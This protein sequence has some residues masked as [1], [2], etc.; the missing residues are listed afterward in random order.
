MGTK[1]EHIVDGRY[2]FSEIVD[3]NRLRNMLGSFSRAT[4][5]GCELVTHPGWEELI[6]TGQPEI[7]GEFCRRYPATKEIC[8]QSKRE[9]NKLISKKEKL[10]IRECD[11]G[12]TRG[13]APVVIQG[14]HAVDLLIGPVLLN[15]PGPKL[16]RKRSENYG[17]DWGSYLNALRQLPVAREQPLREA[18]SFLRDMVVILAERGLEEVKS[19]EAARE[20]MES[21]DNLHTTLSSIGDAV[22]ATDID[23]RIEH[24]NPIAQNLTGWAM[25]EA[26][27][28]KLEKV[29][30]IVNSATGEKAPNPVSKVLEEGKIVG[31]ANHTR[32]ISRDGNQYQIADSGS[33]IKDSGGK[34]TGVVLVF[35]DVSEEYRMREE[36]RKS[37]E[38]LDLAMSI[39][40][41]GVWDW[42]LITDDV[43]FDKRYYE[44][45]G[46]R[47]GEFP[48]RLEEFQ[49]RTHPKDID[50]VMEN[51]RKY[52]EGEIPRFSVEFRFRKKR[53][54]WMW[55]LG[56]GRIVER[57]EDSR[58]TRFVGTHTDITDRKMAEE[59]LLRS[60][61]RMEL[62]L[63]GGDLGAWDWNVASGELTFDERWAEMLGYLKDEIEPDRTNWDKLVHPDD[64]PAV[65]KALQDHLKGRTE[66]FES[67][68]RLLH[69]SGEWVWILAKGMVIERDSEGNPL[70]ACGTHLDITDR[71]K[72]Q[73]ELVQSAELLRATLE[74]T[75]NGILVVNSEGQILA[76]NEKFGEMW[77]IPSDLLIAGRDNSLLKYVKNQLV[78]PE[79]FFG[80]V[81]KLYQNPE[82]ISLDI[83]YFQDGRI[84]ER[85]S[86]PLY[87][88]GEAEGRVWSFRD[89][90]ERKRAEEAL[91]TSEEKYRTLVSSMSD[92]IFLLSGEDRFVDVHCKPGGALYACPED[93]LGKKIDEVLPP[94]VINSYRETAR[95]VRRTGE[96]QRYEYPLKIGERDM[97]FTATLD[98]HEDGERVIADIRDVTERKKAQD[99]L[100]R[101]QKLESVGTLAG[102]IAHDFNNILT[103]LYGN[104]ELAGKEL[105]EDHPAYSHIQTANQSLERA[106]HLTKQLLT[107]AKGGEPLLESVDIRKVVRDSVQFDL[108]GSNVKAQLDLDDNLWMVK[109]DRG[110]LSHVFANL[111]INA[112]EAMPVGGFIHIS[113]ENVIEPEEGTASHLAGDYVKI[114]IR[115]EGV[116]IP[117][118]LIERIFDPYF[119]TKQAGSGLGL[120]IVHSIVSKHYGHITA[121]SKEGEGTVFT[122]YL[123]ADKSYQEVPGG[124]QEDS[125][126]E[127][128]I[129]RGRILVMD[130]EEMVRNVSARMLK[131]CG[132]APELAVNGKD[133][134]NKYLS[135]MESGEP[136]EAV[137]VDLTVPGGMGGKKLTEELLKTDPDARIIVTSGYSTDPVLANYSQYGFSGRIAKPFQVKELRKELSRVL[138]D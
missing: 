45:A 21:E 52:L 65:Q 134:L 89:I 54:G 91:K 41:E 76:T 4:R 38:R 116:G 81:E 127:T 16:F 43:F 80:R 117:D 25:E 133:A 110:Q 12:L 28:K 39:K 60:E 124:E 119:T 26:E 98:L 132:Y 69:K 67:E 79:E 74:S 23:G 61:E 77:K 97:W 24:M 84:F 1:T 7:C 35:R 109:A 83:V 138:G 64:F 111:I 115:D 86:Q 75:N 22:I 17:F 50:Y 66:S 129:E 14:E 118:Q 56:R 137:I 27:G 29:F 33:P 49:K 10:I 19:R 96:T 92:I 130:D 5:Y 104:I 93:F 85:Y 100:Q 31:M 78:D 128:D 72:A 55:I 121:R 34:V 40:N 9:L 106:K 30:N 32:L 13:A 73:E 123:P 99:A 47:P 68:H 58:P 94:E 87:I 114:I 11:D 2:S 126:E 63:K 20:A 95:E 122:M 120:A 125:G 70:R 90:T 46:Y 15:E 6:S 88:K 3:I 8:E 44:M 131:I 51:A 57:D 82:K 18:L 37:E 103:G 42:D 108:S 59:A 135:A 102:G 112:K 71:K 48:S 36:L 53:G 136:F 105:P 62:A 101:M 107:F 113:A